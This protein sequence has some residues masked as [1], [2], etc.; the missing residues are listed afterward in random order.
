MRPESR[1]T[2]I[3]VENPL[4]PCVMPTGMVTSGEL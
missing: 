1:A 4:R 3:T 2:S